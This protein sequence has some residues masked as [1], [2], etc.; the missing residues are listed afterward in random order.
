MPLVQRN[1]TSESGVRV[2]FEAWWHFMVLLGPNLH[3]HVESV[4]LPFL[5]FCYGQSEASVKTEVRE[6]KQSPGTPSSPA[7]KHS[8]LEKLCLDAVL[9]LVA[10]RPLDPALPRPTLATLP[11]PALLPLQVAGHSEEVRIIYLNGA[12]LMKPCCCS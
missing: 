1:V 2:K 12:F 6:G 3:H 8:A 4:V 10:P 9:Q 7:K 11:A 5:R